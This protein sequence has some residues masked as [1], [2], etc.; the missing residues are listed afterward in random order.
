MM[1][2]ALILVLSLLL[3]GGHTAGLQ[4]V[5]WSS[6]FAARVQTA[7]NVGEAFISTIDGSKPCRLCKVVQQLDRAGEAPGAMPDSVLKTVK[8]PQLSEPFPVELLPVAEAGLCI[9]A[10]AVV[11][12]RPRLPADVEV[13]PPR[14]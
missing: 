1:R 5:A 12:F 2:R 10:P 14:I 7:R 11:A 8:K 3:V 4:V 13:P 9:P 6:M